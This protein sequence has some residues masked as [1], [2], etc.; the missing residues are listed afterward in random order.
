MKSKISKI[1]IL[2]CL[3]ILF[4]IFT[5]S[6]HV[7]NKKRVVLG[8]G[9]SGGRVIISMKTLEPPPAGSCAGEPCT[10]SVTFTTTIMPSGGTDS[11]FCFPI[12]NMPLTGP[13]ISASSVGYKLLGYWTVAKPLAVSINWGTAM[14]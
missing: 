4:F 10:C 5:C 2:F 8:A 3:S 11:I 13:S 7:F 6:V 14:Q 9:S 1:N 12:A